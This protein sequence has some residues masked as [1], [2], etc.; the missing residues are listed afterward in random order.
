MLVLEAL[1]IDRR[2]ISNNILNITGWKG[3][4][5]IYLY[6]DRDK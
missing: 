1:G 2:I 6:Q 3:A 5:W 4:K